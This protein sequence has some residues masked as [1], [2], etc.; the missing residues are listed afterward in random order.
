[1]RLKFCCGSQICFRKEKYLRFF[2]DTEI[3]EASYQTTSVANPTTGQTTTVGSQTTDQTTAAGSLTTDQTGAGGNPA[4][5]QTVQ[6]LNIF[7][8]SDLIGVR[9]S[10]VYTLLSDGA[11]HPL[12]AKDVSCDMETDCGG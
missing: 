3:N 6:N 2:L 7:D 5:D 4:M 1:M 9:Q 8:C 12:T 10:G 11:S